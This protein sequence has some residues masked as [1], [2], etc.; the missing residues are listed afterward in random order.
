MFGYGSR[1]LKN[2]N[3]TKDGVSYQGEYIVYENMYIRKYV[4]F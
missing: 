3:Y 1:S 4:S 2:T